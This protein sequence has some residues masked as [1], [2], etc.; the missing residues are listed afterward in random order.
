MHR[1]YIDLGAV[2]QFLLPTASISF[3]RPGFIDSGPV[4]LL[5]EFV[6]RGHEFHF[7]GNVC[8]LTGGRRFDKYCPLNTSRC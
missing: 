2:V 6:K 1:V 5:M 7:P 4:F 8:S 3:N